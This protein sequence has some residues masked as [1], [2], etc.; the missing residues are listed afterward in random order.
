MARWDD[1]DYWDDAQER[2][3][4]PARRHRRDDDEEPPPS[5]APLNPVEEE[6]EGSVYAISDPLWGFEVPDRD[7][8]PGVCVRVDIKSSLTFCYKGTDASRARTDRFPMVVV[9]Q[10]KQNGLEKQTAFSLEP[11]R[12]PLPILRKIH[13]QGGWKG[14]LESVY[15]LRLQDHLRQFERRPGGPKR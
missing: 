4:V 8:H 13:N 12:I 9:E 15:L 3:S 5:P 14:S 6:L 7:W 10:S 2:A 11:H 1:D